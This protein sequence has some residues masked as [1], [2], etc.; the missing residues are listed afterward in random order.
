MEVFTYQDYLKCQKILKEKENIRKKLQE[1]T[2]EYIETKRRQEMK[3][4]TN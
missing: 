3:Q 4:L 2:K 1:K